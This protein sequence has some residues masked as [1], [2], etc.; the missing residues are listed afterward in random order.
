M[1]QV[2]VRSGEMGACTTSLCFSATL[3]AQSAHTLSSGI[4]DQ[5]L[6]PRNA[7]A[8][9]ILQLWVVETAPRRWS[10]LGLGQHDGSTNSRYPPTT[11]HPVPLPDA[12][13]C[14]RPSKLALPQISTHHA[15]QVKQDWQHATITLP[16]STACEPRH[17]ITLRHEVDNDTVRSRRRLQYDR[18]VRPDVT[19]VCPASLLTYVCFAMP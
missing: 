8:S 17:G 10:G 11:T 13:L 12:S 19:C 16:Y 7:T 2:T 14:L 15:K 6:Q 18:R 4:Y 9:S 1:D 3:Y 5:L